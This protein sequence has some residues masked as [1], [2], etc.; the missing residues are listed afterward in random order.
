M[1]KGYCCFPPSLE[2]LLLEPLLCCR[3]PLEVVDFCVGAFGVEAFGVVSF[4][5]VPFVLACPLR[6]WLRLA[7]R[8]PPL[9]LTGIGL[10]SGPSPT[11]S[12]KGNFSMV[13]SRNFSICMNM[14]IS[15]PLTSVMAVPVRLALAVR[16]MRWT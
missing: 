4:G 1:W 16:P 13:L 15:R 11:P 3:F 10:Y 2:S 8:R 7:G 9:P 6:F 5:V 14:P 12:G